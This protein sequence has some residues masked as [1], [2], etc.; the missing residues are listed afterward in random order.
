MDCMQHLCPSASPLT[1][2]SVCPYTCFCLLSLCVC[3]RA[4]SVH[5]YDHVWCIFFLSLIS[6][7]VCVHTV[8]ERG[9]TYKEP[10]YHT[11]TKG[12]MN[13]WIPLGLEFRSQIQ[14]TLAFSTFNVMWGSSSEFCHTEVLQMFSLPMAGGKGNSGDNLQYIKC[15]DMNETHLWCSFIWKQAVYGVTGSVNNLVQ[16]DF[17][18]SG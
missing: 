18:C 7:H 5:V 11:V 17:Y 15:I 1:I 14:C 9:T 4:A 10:C 8:M 6:I 3:V 13:E 16:W 12:R 2:R